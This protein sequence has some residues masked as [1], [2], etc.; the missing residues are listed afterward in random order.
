MC[1]AKLPEIST[2]TPGLLDCDCPGIL[3]TGWLVELDCA[4][5]QRLFDINY[6]GVLRTVQVQT[7]SEGNFVHH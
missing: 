2:N 5:A 3:V 1:C 6:F 4:A 7:I